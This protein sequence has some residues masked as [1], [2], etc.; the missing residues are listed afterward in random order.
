MSK[1]TVKIK[2]SVS[3]KVSVKAK[4]KVKKVVKPSVAV[5]K[6]AA[7]A[8]EEKEAVVLQVP[9]PIVPVKTDRK[10][11]FARHGTSVVWIPGDNKGIP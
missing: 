5:K 2:K 8:K 9:Q 7:K 11:E 1:K 4:T 3:K 10:D 6:T